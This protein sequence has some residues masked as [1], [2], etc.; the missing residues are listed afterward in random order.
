MTNTIHSLTTTI[1]SFPTLPAVVSKVMEITAN[2]DSSIEDL[3]KIIS[4]DQSLTTTILK[5]ANS[6]FYGISRDVSSIKRALTVLGFAE[7][8]KAV[9]TKAVFNSFKGIDSSFDIKKFWEHSFMCGLIAKILAKKAGA[10]YN[11]LFVAGLIHDIGK[12]VIYLAVPNKFSEIVESPDF[13]ELN[14]SKSEKELLGTS[15]DTIGMSLLKRWMFPEQLLMSV[16]F[17]HNPAKATK[18]REF[19]YF[20][21][22]ADLLSY[23]CSEDDGKNITAEMFDCLKDKPFMEFCENNSIKLDKASIDKLIVEINEQKVL[24]KEAFDLL[25]S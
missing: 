18:Q 12:L 4:L 3:I 20:I 9:L 1:N 16:G 24:E 17:H 25:L 10:S 5:L 11:D 6:A 14:S 8:Q 19:P 2:P 22:L 15:H 21:Q 23:H 7:I 13:D